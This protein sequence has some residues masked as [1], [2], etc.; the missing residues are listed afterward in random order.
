MDLENV[1]IFSDL[2]FQKMVKQLKR[3]ELL[4]L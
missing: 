2:Q 1:L 4:L 3:E